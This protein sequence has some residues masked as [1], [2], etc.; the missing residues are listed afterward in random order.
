MARSA[1][2]VSVQP[3]PRRFSITGVD[4]VRMLIAPN[5]GED[6]KPL[7]KIASG[8][9]LSRLML[10][11]KAITAQTNAVPTMVFDEIDTG[12]SGITAQVIARKLWDIARFRQ[13][14][15]VSHLHQIAAMASTQMEVEKVEHA[16]RT[17]TIIHNLDEAER[18]ASLAVMLGGAQA[19]QRSGTQHA[20]ALLDEAASYRGTHP[21]ASNQDE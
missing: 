5:L 11:M 20:Q 4:E 21:L 19:Q 17:Q 6:F 15:C 7:A 16:G 10:A 8:G 2:Q 14:I 13:V 3:D 18:V 1:F 9:E 12:I